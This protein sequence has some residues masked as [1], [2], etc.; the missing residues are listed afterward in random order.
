MENG[1]VAHYAVGPLGSGKTRW[2]LEQVSHWPVSQRLILTSN[3]QR[4]AQF[5]ERLQQLDACGDRG[6]YTYTGWVRTCLYDHWPRVEAQ[7]VAAKLPGTSVI[8]PELSGYRD[9][10]S[11]IQALVQRLRQQDPGAFAG[12]PGGDGSLT[13]Q[14]LRRLRQRSENRLTRQD[15]ANRSEWLEEPCLQAVNTVER[16][17]DRWSY[18]LR[19][20]DPSKQLDMFHQLLTQDTDFQGWM[21]NRV[22]CLAVDDWDETIPAQH[23]FVHAMRGQGL[24][25]LAI[26]C[27][28]DGGSRRGY[29]NAYP[30]DWTGLLDMQPGHMTTLT[31]QDAWTTAADQ[32]LT[33]WKQPKTAENAAT[34]LPPQIYQRHHL[35]TQEEQLQQLAATVYTWLDHNKHTPGNIAIALPDLTLFNQYQLQHILPGIPLQW[36]SGT[37]TPFQHPLLRVFVLLVQWL[38]QANWQQNPQWQLAPLT[39]LELRDILRFWQHPLWQQGF[40]TDQLETD[41]QLTFWWDFHAAHHAMATQDQLLPL[42]NHAIAPFA[43]AVTDLEPVTTLIQRYQARFLRIHHALF[44][45]HEMDSSTPDLT[46]LTWIIQLKQGFIAESPRV[47]VALNPD[48]L[49]IGTPQKL[50]DAEVRRPCYIWLDCAN[51]EWHRSDNAPL[52]NAWVHSAA[53]QDGLLPELSPEGLPQDEWLV[54]VRAAHICRHLMLLLTTDHDHHQLVCL[55]S[56][57]D[58]LHRPLAGMLPH[59]LPSE[60][61]PVLAAQPFTLRP[62]QAPI[63]AYTHGTMAI[64]A[65]P[66]AGKTFVTVALILHLINQQGLL[67]ER[68]LVLTYMDSAAKT[69]LSRLRPHLG[70]RLPQVS[71]IHSLAYRL[72]R[73]GNHAHRLGLDVDTL[74]ILDETAQ[75]NL[76]QLVAAQTLPANAHSVDT[77]AST[78]QSGLNRLKAHGLTLNHLADW[79]TR[80]PDDER[81]QEFFHAAN[82]YHTLCQQQNLLDFN[83][84]IQLSIRLLTEHEDVRAYYQQ[85][86][87]L[88]IED[89]AQDSSA[90]LQELLG[91]LGGHQPNLIRTGDSNQSISATFSGADASVFRRF[92]ASADKAITMDGSGRC[93]PEIMTIANQWMDWCQANPGTQQAFIP[94]AMQPVPEVNPVLRHPIQTQVFDT[95]ITERNAVLADVQQA[96]HQDTTGRKAVLVRTNYQA[97]DW[98]NAFM[99]AGIP[100]VSSAM[101]P[102]LT[103]TL[104]CVFAWLYVL[105]EPETPHRLSSF[106]DVYHHFDP[107]VTTLWPLIEDLPITRLNGIA[108]PLAQRL[109]YDWLDMSRSLTGHTQWLVTLAHHLFQDPRAQHITLT[110]ADKV[111][112]MVQALPDPTRWLCENQAML[113]TMLRNLLKRQHDGDIPDSHVLVTTMHTAKGQE[114]DW[115]WMPELTGQQYPFTLDQVKSKE[116]Q[117][118]FQLDVSLAKLS[119]HQTVQRD[120]IIDDLRQEKLEEEARLLYVGLTRARRSLWLSAAEQGQTRYGKPLPLI[121]HPLIYLW[122]SNTL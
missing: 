70:S 6:V 91:L 61:I 102:L 108:H 100:C 37:A 47:P 23:Q 15:M 60:P 89:E 35:L 92:V 67:P 74:T 11:L 16:L 25:A 68:I 13:R 9:S 34:S 4:K 111:Q 72:V 53:W 85:H 112:P 14:L 118:S 79:L 105:R 116:R 21:T 93:A 58:M 40:T 22:R 46:G 113:A 43:D 29:L 62:D 24:Q 78:L 31:R 114:Y 19:L 64:S 1:L 18:Q 69:L 20:L 30:Y 39:Q 5:T 50:I 33:H 12:F 76:V 42:F 90:A 26:T 48:C 121:P 3:S 80:H 57:T 117:D 65:V 38:N 44:A 97:T 41:A 83:D 81:I 52:Y 7:L 36:L 99:Q 107:N 56:E 77:W 59:M 96:L 54:R 28:P 71:T 119:T 55:S 106:M 73:H 101:P 95:T 120:K 110:L 66:G 32:L 94:V 122:K 82:L 51:P 86:I 103:E 87:H 104:D 10:E 63:L 84:L 2:L 109:Y 75:L 49:V 8:M 27:D 45:Q 98:I 115:V 88:I 17:F